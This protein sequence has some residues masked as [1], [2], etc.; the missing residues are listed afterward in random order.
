[1]RRSFRNGGI[2]VG[3]RRAFTFQLEGVVLLYDA[4]LLFRQQPDSDCVTVLTCTPEGKRGRP[5]TTRRRT[6]EK[7]RSRAGWQS[8]REMRTA[9]QDRN[10]WRVSV[11]ALCAVT[12]VKTMT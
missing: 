10:R 9:A 4:L 7:E 3:F 5:K 2:G 12:L 6:V 8:W 11:K 1:M